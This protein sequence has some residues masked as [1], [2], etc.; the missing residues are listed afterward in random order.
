LALSTAYSGNEKAAAQMIDSEGVQEAVKSFEQ[1]LMYFSNH[2][3]GIVGLDNVP[4]DFSEKK[5]ELGRRVDDGKPKEEAQERV[6][7]SAIKVS[8]NTPGGT[9]ANKQA[10]SEHHRSSATNATPSGSTPGQ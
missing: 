2:V 4:F 9:P 5:F 3:K 7:P 6:K 1:C 10:S 8:N